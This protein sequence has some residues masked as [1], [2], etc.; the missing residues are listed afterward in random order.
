MSRQNVVPLRRRPPS[1]QE[2]EVYRWMTRSWS[3]A[4][5]QLILPEYYRANLSKP[6]AVLQQRRR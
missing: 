1:Q 2:L 5:R 6:R 4:L 3:P